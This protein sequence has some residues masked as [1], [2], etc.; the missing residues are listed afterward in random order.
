MNGLAFFRPSETQCKCGCGHDIDP[1]LLDRLNRLR[2]RCN[3]PLILHS[4]ARC[5]KHNAAVGGAKA[6]THLAGLAADIRWPVAPWDRVKLLRE[7]VELGFSGFGFY[8]TFL[9]LDIRHIQ[10]RSDSAWTGV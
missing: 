8:T 2:Y 9:H 7:A 3:F 4:G 6:S 1:R 10:G 5:I